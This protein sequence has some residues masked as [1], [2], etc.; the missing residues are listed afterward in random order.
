[1]SRRGLETI[2]MAGLVNYEEMLAR[3]H[4]RRDAVAR[5]DAPETLYLL[6]HA[7]VITLGRSARRE[8]LLYSEAALREKGIAVCECDR[9]GDVTYHGPG[10]LVAYPIVRL[11]DWNASVGA[12]LRGLEAVIIEVLGTYGLCGERVPGY[13]G[14]WVGGAKAAAIGVGVHRWVT[15]HGAA[16][17]VR[18]DL[19]HF[20]CIVPCGIADRPVTSLERLLPV[21]PTVAQVGDRF[22]ACFRAHF[23]FA[24]A[25]SGD[26]AAVC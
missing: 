21:S 24:A 14:V 16:I 3:Q 23:G 7:P 25:P 8:H 11:Q 15:Y 6:E 18:P 12:Y 13:T 10:Q 26:S 9:G 19:R 17:N 20:A 5:G 4:A 2:R 22:D 1:M